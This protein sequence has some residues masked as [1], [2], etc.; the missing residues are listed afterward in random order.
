MSKTS[1]QTLDRI[2]PDHYSFS[3]YIRKRF[4]ILSTGNI[5]NILLI[6]PKA[7]GVFWSM[8]HAM[9]L[10]G[11]KTVYPPLSLLTIAAMLPSDWHKRL[12]DLNVQS[13]GEN[14]LIYPSDLYGRYYR[15]V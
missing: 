1:I 5:M 3:L 14:D 4:I 11:K 15:E 12:V 13:L 6:Y 7:P 2:F 9:K 10:I 8:K